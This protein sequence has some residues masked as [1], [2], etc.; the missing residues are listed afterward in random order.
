MRNIFRARAEHEPPAHTAGASVSEVTPAH[1]TEQADLRTALGDAKRSAEGAPEVRIPERM[2]DTYK[3]RVQ[4]EALKGVRG[5]T[6]KK[7]L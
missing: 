4:L 6:G 5:D 2:T 7:L 3:K 1:K